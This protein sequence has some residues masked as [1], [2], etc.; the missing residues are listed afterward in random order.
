M[1]MTELIKN[2]YLKSKFEHYKNLSTKVEEEDYWTK[3][4]VEY[5]TMSEAEQETIRS[6]FKDNLV[7]INNKLKEI[8]EEIQSYKKTIE[9]YPKNEEEV[10]LLEMVLKKMGIGFVLR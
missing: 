10:Q 3:A 7:A 2:K 1:T 9:V 4:K 8:D 6:A 5:D